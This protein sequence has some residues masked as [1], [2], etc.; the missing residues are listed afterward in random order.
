M[1]PDGSD[2]RALTDAGADGMVAAEPAWSPAG[3]RIAF[4][5]STPEHLGPY[6]GDGDV[7]LMNADGTRLVQLTH[8]LR[9]FVA[10]PGQSVKMKA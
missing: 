7:F 4:V 6:A 8:G 9:A 5:L 1:E 2:V 10:G 3:T